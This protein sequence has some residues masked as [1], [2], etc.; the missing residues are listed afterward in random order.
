MP[1]T[2][3]AWLRARPRC[4][5]YKAVK[6]NMEHKRQSRLSYMEHIR[7]SSA[8]MEHIR[9]SRLESGT[10]KGLAPRAPSRRSL[11]ERV[12]SFYDYFQIF[13]PSILFFRFAGASFYC[14]FQNCG[15][16]GK[17]WLRAL[18]AQPV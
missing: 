18:D 2:G 10:W 11:S 4:A 1:A 13:G 6:A 3:K 15:G 12:A 7:Q 17:A 5:A 8:N 14:Y 16:P 9:Q